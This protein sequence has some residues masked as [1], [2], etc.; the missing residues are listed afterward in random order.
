MLF[1]F[2]FSCLPEKKILTLHTIM[3]ISV[4][5]CT[6]NAATVLPATLDSVRLQSHAD[7]EHIIV[8]GAS[9]DDTMSV[10]EQYQQAE[11]LHRVVVVSE[12]DNGLYDAMNKG[13]RLAT[14]RYLVF[15]NAGDKF[16]SYDTLAQVSAKAEGKDYGVIYGDTEIVDDNGHS[17]GMRRLRP[18]EKL[19]WQ[20]FSNGM[21]VCHQ[22][23]YANTAVAKR[24]EYDTR[25]R[26]SADVDWCIRVMKTAEAEGLKNLNTHLTLCRYLDGGMSVKNHRASLIE[27][28]QVMRIH[29]GLF[30]TIYK[31]IT[32]F[33][34]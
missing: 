1:L 20:S 15:L 30:K 6:Y 28:F 2:A 22:A 3:T 33:F 26:L 5:T 32:F 8:D 13:I 11:Q 10:V 7:V 21:L 12:K 9:A 25:Y 23:F 4:I 19:T 14:G 17:I 27:R 29:Y 18:P 16:Y 31:H 34:R 24:V